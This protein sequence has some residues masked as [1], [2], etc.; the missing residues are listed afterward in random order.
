MFDMEMIDWISLLLKA[1]D[2]TSEKATSYLKEF[3]TP[4]SHIVTSKYK[5]FIEK[6]VSAHIHTVQVLIS[7]D[8]YCKSLCARSVHCHN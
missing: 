1:V 3:V 7:I 5:K 8:K 2:V 6:T 4:A